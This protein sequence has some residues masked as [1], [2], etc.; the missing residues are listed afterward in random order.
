MVEKIPL[1]NV[2]A[3]DSEHPDDEPER[4]H[5]DNNVPDPLTDC[6]G[7]GA[8]WHNDRIPGPTRRAR[9]EGLGCLACCPALP[10]REYCIILKG[11]S[12]SEASDQ[13]NLETTANPRGLSSVDRNE[14]RSELLH[15]MVARLDSS[16]VD[17]ALL[18]D[19]Q[20]LSPEDRQKLVK[21]LFER[22]SKRENL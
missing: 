14:D 22:E 7:L 13:T 2:D 6:P 19:L 1:Q 21:I 10:R 3:G 8:I 5:G 15:K 12:A 4:Y 17:E 20:K 18:E 9:S 16:G 11:L